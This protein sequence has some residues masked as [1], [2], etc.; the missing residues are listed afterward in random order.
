M[1]HFDSQEWSVFSCDMFPIHKQE[2]ME[3]HLYKCDEC[4]EVFLDTIDENAVNEAYNLIPADFTSKTL[5]YIENHSP[6]TVPITRPKRKISNMFTYYVAA[7]LLTIFFVSSGVFNSLAHSYAKINRAESI[8][9]YNVIDKK[10]DFTF[11]LAKKLANQTAH[12][13]NNFEKKI[14]EEVKQ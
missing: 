4:I 8:L 14:T 9:T 7:A 12:W 1:K 5:A 13:I 3:E 10:K 11:N 2:Q 6:K